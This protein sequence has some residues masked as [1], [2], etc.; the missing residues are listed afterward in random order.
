M[1][2][3]VRASHDGVGRYAVG[4]IAT[5]VSHLI[6]WYIAKQEL[7]LEELQDEM[8]DAML[9]EDEEAEFLLSEKLRHAKKGLRLPTKI[10]VNTNDVIDTTARLPDHGPT[11]LL[12]YSG[13]NTS[14]SYAD[15]R[16]IV[17]VDVR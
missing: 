9:S 14:R 15:T 17:T 5:A 4:A 16:V 7:I 1:L 2:T 10:E 3:C 12:V 13:R 11:L 6:D 8:L